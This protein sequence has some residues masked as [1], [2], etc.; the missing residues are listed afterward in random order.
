[1]FP[2]SNKLHKPPKLQ[3]RSI[4]PNLNSCNTFEGLAVTQAFYDDNGI[5]ID[6]HTDL[7]FTEDVGKRFEGY[8]W[9]VPPKCTKTR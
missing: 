5:T 7:S 1:L 6:G 8:G 9:Q 3:K 4:L 2:G